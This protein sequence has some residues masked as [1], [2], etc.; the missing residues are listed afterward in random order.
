MIQC[1]LPQNVSD[2]RAGTIILQAEKTARK[3]GFA[4]ITLLCLGWLREI[5]RIW[6]YGSYAFRDS[7]DFF[8]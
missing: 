5:D 6:I 3:P 8:R 2:H 7:R 1:Y 4:C